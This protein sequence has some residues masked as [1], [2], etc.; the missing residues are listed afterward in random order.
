FVHT[1]GDAHL[2][3]NHLE[4]AKRQLE[5][6]PRALARMRI[7]SERR[8]LFAFQYED[9]TLEGYDPHPHIAAEV[10]V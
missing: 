2:Y 4:Q 6:Q 10:S 7:N 3:K 1:M 5:R 8:D 9:F